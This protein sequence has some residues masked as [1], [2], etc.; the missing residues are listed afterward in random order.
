M[1]NAIPYLNPLFKLNPIESKLVMVPW[2]KLYTVLFFGQDSMMCLRNLHLYTSGGGLKHT[3]VSNFVS[4]FED[5]DHFFRENASVGGA[6]VIS[7]FSNDAVVAVGND[8]TAYGKRHR[9]IKTHL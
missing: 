5:L 1:E 6:F 7:R 9:E 4:Y 2:N 3:D 8:E